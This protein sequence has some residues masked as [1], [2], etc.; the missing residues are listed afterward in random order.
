MSIEKV[1]TELVYGD[2]GMRWGFQIKE[3]EKRHR[4]FKLGLDPE[5]VQTDSKLVRDYPDD[6]LLPPPYGCTP[7]KMPTDFLRALRQH[8]YD[9]MSTKLSPTA[10][11][12]SIF[13]F[14]VPVCAGVSLETAATLTACPLRFLH[15]GTTARRT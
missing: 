1:P 2:D 3:N 5:T 7:E 10:I 12:N 14:I 9:A 4:W 11:E 6:T 15:C 8:V 13:V